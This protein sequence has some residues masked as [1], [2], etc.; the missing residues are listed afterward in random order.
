MKILEDHA[1]ERD[2]SEEHETLQLTSLTK[3]VVL[4][5]RFWF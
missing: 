4:V 3:L 5:V 1:H 2:K